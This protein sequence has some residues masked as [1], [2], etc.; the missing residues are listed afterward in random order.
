MPD[1]LIGRGMNL[2]F[3]DRGFGSRGAIVLGSIGAIVPVPVAVPAALCFGVRFHASVQN[4][5]KQAF[6]LIDFLLSL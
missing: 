1:Y 5:R 2:L 6:T 3:L 4:G